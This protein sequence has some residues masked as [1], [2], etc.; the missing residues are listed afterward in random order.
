MNQRSMIEKSLFANIMKNQGTYFEC[1][2][3]LEECHMKI[4]SLSMLAK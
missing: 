4:D 3:T 2:N 1:L